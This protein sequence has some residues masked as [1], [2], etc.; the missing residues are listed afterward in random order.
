M[1]FLFFGYITDHP[2]PGIIVD[3]DTPRDGLGELPFF[4]GAES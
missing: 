2:G 1:I 3:E 4:L